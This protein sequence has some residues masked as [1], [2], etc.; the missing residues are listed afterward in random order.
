M[1]GFV[2]HLIKERK[3]VF[4]KKTKHSDMAA[5]H[6]LFANKAAN[7]HSSRGGTE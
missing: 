2:S 1:H 7:I 4:K 5:I 3:F 6:H